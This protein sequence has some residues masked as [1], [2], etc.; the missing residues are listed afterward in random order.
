MALG[1]VTR[2][3]SIAL[4][5]ATQG[6]NAGLNS[7]SN[8]LGQFARNTDGQMSGIRNTM[9]GMSAAA[10]AGFGVVVSAAMNF[11]HAMSEVAAVSGATGSEFQ[12]LKDQ[13]IELGAETVYSASE[14]AK[15]QAELAKA[16][17]TTGDIL[18]GA[19]EGTL[20]LAA[21]AGM[22][23]A[24]AAEISA[25]ALNTFGLA[26]RDVAHV[27][28]VL[29]AAA[30]KSATDVPEMGLA[31][32]QTGLVADQLGI[33]LEETAGTL[34][35]FAQAGL[36]GSDA[37][38]S[39]KTMLMRLNP[40][41][42]KA[43]SAMKQAGLDFFDAA[44][45]FV[46][47]ERAAGQ[48]HAQLSELS[49][50][51]RMQTLQTIFGQDAIRAA[52]LLYEQGSKGIAY[53]TSQVD[54][55]GYAAQVAARRLDNL[56]GDVEALSG[57]IDSV[58]IRSGEDSVGV[59]REVTQAAT[60]AV[61]GFSELPT[62]VQSGGV[63]LLGL[64]GVIGTAVTGFGFLIPALQNAKAG[65]IAMGGA[66]Q[67]AATQMTMANFRMAA[68]AFTG[69]GIAAGFAL[70]KIGN[71]EAK[72]KEMFNTF[73]QGLDVP[74]SMTTYA[75]NINR[76]VGEYERLQ[77]VAR[78]G[79]NWDLANEFFN[80][81]NEDTVTEASRA[82]HQ[83]SDAIQQA[84]AE[85]MGLDMVLGS[86]MNE[87][88]LSEE[89]IYELAEVTGV[90]L[91]GAIQGAMS[92]TD[93][94]AIQWIKAKR[95]AEELTP[96]LQGNYDALH[97]GGPVV[98]SVA[99]D[100]GTM[101]DE[102]KDAKEQLEGW[103]DLWQELLGF[104]FS[105][106]E[107]VD[108]LHEALQGL[109]DAVNKYKETTQGWAIPG[110]ALTAQTEGARGLRDALQ[111][112]AEEDLPALARTWA[113]AGI[114]GDEF[115]AKLNEQ[116]DMLLDTAIKFGVPEDA[117]REYFEVLRNMPEYV[118][119]QIDQPGMAE[120]LASTERLD[121]LLG[122]VRLGAEGTVTIHTGAA[123][124]AL[125][126]LGGQLSAITGG[127]LGAAARLVVNSANGNIF[128][129]FAAGGF[130]PHHATLAAA[131]SWR[132]WGEPETGGEAYIPLSPAKRGRSTE[133]LRQTNAMMGSPLDGGAGGVVV[134]AP[135][136]FN[137]SAPDYVGSH[138]ELA[139]AVEV[140]ITRDGRVQDA[141]LRAARAAS[142]AR[143]GGRSR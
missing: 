78:E 27:A 70:V 64:V 123:E 108:N 30:N 16:G 52:T 12:R 113:E 59:L 105:E 36:K 140:T 57:A 40:S 124:A 46:G 37:G 91:V 111:E 126:R 104:V 75:D 60:D 112:I 4:S 143:D 138:D 83:F 65:M 53:W 41:T 69:I 87:L 8:A 67:V 99:G 73:A 10:V 106:Q 79:S 92:G 82:T 129:S 80:P 6:F 102:T 66:A 32:K 62:Q 1:G 15:A 117:A 122:Q 50:E 137:V 95:L 121:Y 128:H 18:G 96:A 42:E 43:A 19:L 7:A 58:L 120:G 11:E 88:G 51:D 68:L 54:D 34:S 115:K 9:A 93:S 25:N 110:Q 141:V 130:E 86:A 21:A 100:M 118:P 71:T 47:L 103:V 61:N 76:L 139:R 55:S 133:I 49:Q 24:Q 89:K 17:V 44:G 98:Q 28:D 136:T 77:D 45:N 127:G 107:A 132:V 119:T 131:G 90:D 23:L 72:A 38:T 134:N 31:L 35:M 13:A 74:E 101:A 22:D 114:T 84:K 39:L 116:V 135:M 33:S 5:L 85:M 20:D 26:G 3:I 48:L 94:F 81:W 97:E 29:A 2:G 125:Y 109:P 63:M 142:A 56:K 14:V